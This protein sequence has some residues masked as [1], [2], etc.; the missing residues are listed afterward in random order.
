MIYYNTIII[1]YIYYNE[2]YFNA[3]QAVL[4]V[5]ERNIPKA[6]KGV[7]LIVRNIPTVVKV[8]PVIVRD[9]SQQ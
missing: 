8:V 5:L 3:S 7:P 4:Y 1:R 6:V 9:T 2:I